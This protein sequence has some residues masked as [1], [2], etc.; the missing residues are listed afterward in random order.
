MKTPAF[1]LS[2]SFPTNVATGIFLF[3]LALNSIAVVWQVQ[4]LL[5]SGDVANGREYCEH[6]TVSCYRVSS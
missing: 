4:T 3:V 5:P 2:G 1:V 6:L